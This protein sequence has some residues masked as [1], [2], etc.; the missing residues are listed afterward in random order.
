MDYVL[1]CLVVQGFMCISFPR[2][3]IFCLLVCLAYLILAYKYLKLYM[4]SFSLLYSLLTNRWMVSFLAY[5]CCRLTILS[6]YHDLLA[7]YEQIMDIA[8]I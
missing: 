2:W 5:L 4:P 7:L 3:I 8:N 6:S 1:V